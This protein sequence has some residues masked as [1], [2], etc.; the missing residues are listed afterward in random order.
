M[1]IIY[2]S[3]IYIFGLVRNSSTV[4]IKSG[5]G[6][7]IRDRQIKEGNRPKVVHIKIHAL[8]DETSVGSP[9]F[10]IEFIV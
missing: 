4:L 3:L 6:S 10:L 7:A 2:H 1:T 9:H 8:I 5:G